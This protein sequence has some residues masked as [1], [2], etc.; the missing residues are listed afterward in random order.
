MERSKYAKA[1]SMNLMISAD[2]REI[3]MVKEII[4]IHELNNKL[5]RDRIKSGC[6]NGYEKQKFVNKIHRNSIIIRGMQQYIIELR[7]EMKEI[8]RRHPLNQESKNDLQD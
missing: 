6:R 8:Q 2:V 4:R 3:A 5:L 7:S 1:L